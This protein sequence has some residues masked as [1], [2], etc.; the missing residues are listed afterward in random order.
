[1]TKLFDK[2]VS[3]NL[4]NNEQGWQSMETAPTD[5]AILAAWG[6]RSSG[7][8]GY[9]IVSFRYGRIWKSECCEGNRYPAGGYDLLAWMPLPALPK[10]D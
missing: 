2:L 8:S 1:M 5:K 10:K 9:D 4:V 6:S 7:P 3:E